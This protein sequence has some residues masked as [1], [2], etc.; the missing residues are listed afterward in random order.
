[1]SRRRVPKRAVK[2]VAFFEGFS[3]TPTDVLDGYSTVGYGHLIAHRPVIAADRQSVWVKGQKTPGRLTEKEARV[4][5]RQD[6]ERFADAVA[7]YV[8]VPINWRQASALISFTYNCGEGALAE[9]T[10][11]ARLNSGNYAGVPEAL[12]W[13]NKGPD[14]V[15]PGLT[16]RRRREGRL[17]RPL[18]RPRIWIWNR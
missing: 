15:L 3:P 4:L 7:A 2:L 14:G 6:L 16:V 10:A 8:K 9:S 18:R 13:W 17:F 1:V 5:L 12:S 11:L